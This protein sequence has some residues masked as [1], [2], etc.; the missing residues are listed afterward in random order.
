MLLPPDIRRE[1]PLPRHKSLWAEAET[2]ARAFL[3]REEPAKR[4]G[5][6]VLA[7]VEAQATTRHQPRFPAGTCRRNYRLTKG[8]KSPPSFLDEQPD[9]AAG[10]VRAA[11]ARIE[12]DALVE[13]FLE[14]LA[15]G[16]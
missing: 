15:E 13:R 8:G 12:Q 14:G 3:F 7:G 5:K 10:A 6:N 9:G 11:R 1:A 16:T 4:A 2:Q